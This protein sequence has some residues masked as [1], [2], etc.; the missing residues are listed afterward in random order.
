M[1][2]PFFIPEIASTIVDVIP[3]EDLLPLTYINECPFLQ[4][5]AV[6]KHYKYYC[7]L[8]RLAP[9]ISLR[10]NFF[11]LDKSLTLAYKGFYF[12]TY[13]KRK[14]TE[15]W[16][17]WFTTDYSQ[18]LG[19]HVGWPTHYRQNDR[20]DRKPWCVDQLLEPWDGRWP[21]WCIY[22]WDAW[23]FKVPPLF[24]C[25]FLDTTRH[26]KLHFKCCK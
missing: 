10:N 13:V 2:H 24:I 11:Y 5:E 1:P 20:S 15:T 17:G 9:E 26:A 16:Y 8:L 6:R 7:H 12:C 4:Q 3:Y 19:I 23:G 21:Q 22:L 25:N 14:G 18:P